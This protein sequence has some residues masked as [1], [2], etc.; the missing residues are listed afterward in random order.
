MKGGKNNIY[1]VVI[2]MTIDLHNLIHI[3]SIFITSREEFL[4]CLPCNN[5]GGVQISDNL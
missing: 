4:V 5:E 3:D 2:I 1:F